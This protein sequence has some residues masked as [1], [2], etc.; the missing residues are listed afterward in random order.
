MNLAK[1]SRHQWFLLVVFLSLLLFWSPLRRLADFTMAHEQYSHIVLIPFVTAYLLYQGRKKVFAEVEYHPRSGVALLIAAIAIYALHRFLGHSLSKNDSLSLLMAAL[2]L[3]WLGGFVCCYGRRSFRAGLFPLLFLFFV[4]PIPDS[5]LSATIRFLQLGSTE[6]TALAFQ[7]LGVPVLRENTVFVLPG[8]TIEVAK[9]CSGIRTS[10][11]L[12][13]TVLLAGHLFL[14]SGW[15]KLSLVL[16]AVPLA[17]FK[18]GLRIVT[19]TLLSVYVDAGFLKG[20]LHRKG[21]VVFF[22]ITLLVTAVFLKILQKLESRPGRAAAAEPVQL[23]R[24]TQGEGK[25]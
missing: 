5:L 10:L 15:S 12:L 18:N 24:D 1:Y 11:A 4:V 23:E 2:V 25:T 13:I 14:R 8:V 9:E 16:L 21:G 20:D 3:V 17:I 22:A 7:L 19:L 6:V